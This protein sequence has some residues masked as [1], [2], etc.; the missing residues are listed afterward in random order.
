MNNSLMPI[1]LRLQTMHKDVIAKFKINRTLFVLAWA[2]TRLNWM[3]PRQIESH[4]CPQL[5]LYSI[6]RLRGW[7]YLVIS[8]FF[9]HETVSLGYVILR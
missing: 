6:G 7:K 2:E 1:A 8:C 9:L 3:V 4:N 5:L